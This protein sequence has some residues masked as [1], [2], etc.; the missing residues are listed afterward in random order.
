[1]LLTVSFFGRA[2]G[3]GYGTSANSRKFDTENTE[4]TEITERRIL[5]YSVFSVDFVVSVLLLCVTGRGRQ[6]GAARFGT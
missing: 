4:D 5:C 6:C 2:A 3:C 1:M